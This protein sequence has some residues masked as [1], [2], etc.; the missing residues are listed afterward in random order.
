MGRALSAPGALS[1]SSGALPRA[2]LPRGWL[3]VVAGRPE[4]VVESRVREQWPTLGGG[5]GN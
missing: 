2:E 3:L 4:Q 5:L 1:A